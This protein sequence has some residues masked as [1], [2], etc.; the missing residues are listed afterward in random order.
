MSA[1]QRVGLP[2]GPELTAALERVA[3][4]EYAAQVAAEEAALDREILAEQARVR[5]ANRQAAYLRNRPAA[6]ADAS[7]A[8]L[9][10]QEDPDGK[11]TRWLD[12]GHRGLVLMGPSSHGKTWGAFAVLNEAS[13]RGVWVAAF[14]EHDLAAATAPVPWSDNDAYWARQRVMR[15]AEQAELLLIDDMGARRADAR[16]LDQLTAILNE[17]EGARLRTLITANARTK[18]EGYTKI[19]D[20]YDSRVDRRIADD[21]VAVWVEG[22]AQR[23]WVPPLNF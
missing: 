8:S 12:S 1:P 15:D 19:A 13:E 7:L 21:A 4:P 9:L 17:R 5:A 23:R 11:V 16:W 22:E 2:A 18:D 10:P 20:M 3:D 6:Y 14:T